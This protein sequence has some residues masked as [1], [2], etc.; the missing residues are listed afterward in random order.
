VAQ[1]DDCRRSAAHHDF[2]WLFETVDQKPNKLTVA[3]RG[4]RRVATIRSP[5]LMAELP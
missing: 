2:T 3:A 4:P 5:P 1:Y